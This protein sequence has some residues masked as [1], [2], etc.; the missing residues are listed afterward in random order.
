MV[1]EGYRLNHAGA[2][3][4]SRRCGRDDRRAVRDASTTPAVVVE[5]VKAAEDGSGDL[6][7]A[8]LRVA[9]RTGRGHAGVRPS[10]TPR[11]GSPTSSRTRRRPNPGRG[12]TSST[13]ARS[14]ISA[15]TVPD[16]DPASDTALRR[17][18]WEDDADPVSTRAPPP[19]SHPDK[20]ADV[21]RR[22]GG[23]VDRRALR[24][25]VIER[26]NADLDPH[27]R[28]PP[29]R[30]QRRPRRLLLRLE[31]QADPGHP[32]QEPDL[33]RPCAPRR[34]AARRRRPHPAAELRRLLDEP[35][36]DDLHRPRQPR[37]GAAPRRPQLEPRGQA[38][39]S[40]CRSR[41]SSRSVTT[42]PRRLD[43]RG[44]GQPRLAARPPDRPVSG[45][46]RS[47]WSPAPR[48]STSARSCTVAATTARPTAGVAPCTS[49]TSSAGS[50]PRRRSRCRSI[51]TWPARS[52]V[53]R[54]SSSVS[55]TSASEPRSVSHAEAALELWQLDG[56]DLESADGAFHHR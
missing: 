40:T 10:G 25:D 53:G 41:C 23:I 12:S 1:A 8:V 46:S 39:A 24:P 13:T 37:P 22:D 29:A 32:R 51:V 56:G 2:R 52:R 48:S 35:G 33:R 30:L 6:D 9:R 47:R 49:P 54:E 27:A 20:L 4:P 5:A 31:H 44:P 43:A 15:E 34:H 50:R 26:L 45:A 16:R 19:D 17:A 11:S 28:R 7:R 18:P 14:R 42:P 3:G 55:P 38:S 21:L 36:R